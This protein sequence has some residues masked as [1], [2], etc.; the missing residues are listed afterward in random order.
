MSPSL[1]SCAEQLVGHHSCPCS[2][3][4]NVNLCPLS[5]FKSFL[6]IL[7]SHQLN[8]NLI[9]MVSLTIFLLES[10]EFLDLKVYTMI[11][12]SDYFFQL[13]LVNFFVKLFYVYA[14]FD[15]IYVF[16]PLV[17]LV[18]TDAERRCGITWY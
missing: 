16:V 18:P 1:P 17:C 13:L 3:V 5:F 11:F 2:S 9:L 7:V 15:C 14:C 4:G 12:F 8:F 6:L 10:F